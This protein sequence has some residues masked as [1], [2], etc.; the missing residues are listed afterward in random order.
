MLIAILTFCGQRQT[1]EKQNYALE[2]FSKISLKV[3][4]V[5]DSIENIHKPVAPLL[6]G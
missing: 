2:M 5:N 4:K 1:V 6:R 3:L